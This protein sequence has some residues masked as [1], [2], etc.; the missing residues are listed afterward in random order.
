[1]T[2]DRDI[3]EYLINTAIDKT[4]SASVSVIDNDDTSLPSITIAGDQTSI[5]EGDVASFTLTATDPV[6][7]QLSVLVEVV[8]TNSGTGDFFAGSSNK[9]TPERISISE[10]TKTGQIEL[11]TIRDADD[12]DDGSISVRIKTDNLA[13]KTYSVGVTHIASITVAR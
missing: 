6:S 10:T 5:I 11:P 12:E 7:A 8:E 4:S 1:M 3:I 2:D 13:T 9:Y